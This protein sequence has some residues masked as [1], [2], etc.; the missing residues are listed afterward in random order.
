MDEPSAKIIDVFR[1][2]HCKLGK[3][4]ANAST[5]LKMDER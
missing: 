1:R 3:K 4:L 5:G 2:I